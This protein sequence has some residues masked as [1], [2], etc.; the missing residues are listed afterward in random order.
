MPWP[1]LKFEAEGHRYW[2]EYEDGT[3]EDIPSVSDILKPLENYSMVDP[4]MLARA[5]EF[6]T[7]VHKAI[8]LWLRGT[9]NEDTLD[10][11][12][13]KP[14]AG[15]KEWFRPYIMSGAKYEV[16]KRRYHPKLKYAGTIDLHIVDE[17]LIDHKTRKFNPI[18]DP[19]R[20][21]AYKALLP[22]E[23]LDTHV[24][25]INVDGNCKLVNAYHRQAWS[26]FRKLLDF[27]NRKKEFEKFIENWKGK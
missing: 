3:T 18:V 19:V 23:D 10:D 6:G 2:L 17:A 4:Q 21:A 26:V 13:K 22:G 24:S 16:E 9:L 12:L 11:G 14:L 8:E 1:V 7:N 27:H 15:T 20:L 25:E 5:S